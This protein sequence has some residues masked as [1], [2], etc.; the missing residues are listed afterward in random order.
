VDPFVLTLV[1]LGSFLGV[2]LILRHINTRP[3][4]RPGRSEGPSGA[5]PRR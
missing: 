3:P 2:A 5:G 1:L 4:A